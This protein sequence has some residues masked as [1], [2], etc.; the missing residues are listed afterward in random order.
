MAVG[1]SGLLL[2]HGS[3]PGRCRGSPG[4]TRSSRWRNRPDILA[5]RAELVADLLDGT[6]G[7]TGLIGVLRLDW[8]LILASARRPEGIGGQGSTLYFPA[9]DGVH[10]LELW[11]T[12]GTVEGDVARGGPPAGASGVVTPEPLGV[13]CDRVLFWR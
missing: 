3:E 12:D 10:G 7:G 13:L 11:R 1:I 2:P 4:P 5:E 9:D 8:Q 6:R